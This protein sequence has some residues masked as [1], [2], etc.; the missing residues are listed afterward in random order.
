MHSQ[1]DA[2]P[3]W[4][5]VPEL[6]ARGSDLT[7]SAEESHYVVRVCRA[8]QGERIEATDGKGTRATLTLI[9]TQ[10]PVRARVESRSVIARTATAELWC[11]AP[12]GQRADWLIE[13]LAEL[14]VSV[15][16]PIDC[17]RA[18][19]RT[20]AVRRDRWERLAIAALRQSQRC[21]QMEIRDPRPL[22]ELLG[23]KRTALQGWFGDEAAPGPQGPAPAGDSIGVIGPAPGL[24]TS[25]KEHLA[26]AGFIPMAL[27]DSRLRTE[28][29]ALAWSAWWGQARTRGGPDSKR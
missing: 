3:S 17:E 16:Q 22:A 25:E 20:N 10:S 5:F 26:A 19:W 14:G 21:H 23:K 1:A 13:K 8:R 27:S 15:W 6:G 12:E 7:L 18:V 9:D 24:S 29:A 4:V 2:A 11:G 28:T